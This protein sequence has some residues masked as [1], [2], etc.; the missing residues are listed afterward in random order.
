MSFGPISGQNSSTIS[1]L[2]NIAYSSVDRPYIKNNLKPITHSMHL[3]LIVNVG[4]S[5]NCM[6]T[7]SLNLAC[8][9]IC[10][11]SYGCCHPFLLSC[12]VLLSLPCQ[13]MAIRVGCTAQTDLR[14]GYL[15]T[16]FRQV[17]QAGTTSSQGQVPNKSGSDKVTLL[18]R[19]ACT[20]PL[21]S[22]NMVICH[23]QRDTHTNTTH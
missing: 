7:I 3:C 20:D 6:I 22:Q 18:P 17:E 5:I 2:T 21:T 15:K 13:T 9:Q 12:Q 1:Q 23:S 8:S 19:E 14:P 4:S 11:C 16:T 10:L